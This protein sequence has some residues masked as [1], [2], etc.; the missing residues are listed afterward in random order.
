MPLLFIGVIL[1][2]ISISFTLFFLRK[3]EFGIG[4]RGYDVVVFALCIISF[5][6]SLKLFLNMGTYADE[7]GSSPVQISGGSFWLSM[8]WIRQGILLI[9]S[10]MTGINLLSKPGKSS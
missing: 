6:V 3:K 4:K 7:F 2:I 9:L 10:I 1:I 8:D 5:I